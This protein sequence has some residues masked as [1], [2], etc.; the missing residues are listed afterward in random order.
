MVR[1][2]SIKPSFFVNDDLA[3][4][5]PLT[6]LLFIGLWC[7]ADREGRME[8][9]PNRIRAAVLPYDVCDVDEMLHQLASKGCIKRYQVAHQNYITIINFAKHQ[10][11]HYKEVA[12]EIPPPTSDDSTS[13]QHQTEVTSTSSRVGTQEGKGTGREHKDL[14][15]PDGD[16]AF[17]EFWKAYPRKVGKKAARRRWDKAVREVE[18]G[19][20]LAALRSYPFDLRE[21]KRFVPH[22]ATWLNQGRWDDEV[23][24]ADEVRWDE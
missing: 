5:D 2:R 3:E 24:F 23:P 20:L 6:R 17:E 16:A 11:P 14:P 21:N 18:A 15:S 1:I 7:L 9:R 10:R 22:P 12:S 8:D 4:L 13:P 19:V